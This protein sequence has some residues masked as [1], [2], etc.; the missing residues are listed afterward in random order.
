LDLRFQNQ[1]GIDYGGRMRYG[2][3]LLSLFLLGC[4]GDTYPSKRIESQGRVWNTC[5]WSTGN[6]LSHGVGF[7]NENHR[8]IYIEGDFIMYDDFSVMCDS[9]SGTRIK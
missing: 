5:Q 9:D 8:W 2:I 6:A 7:Y 1:T 3:L 4:E